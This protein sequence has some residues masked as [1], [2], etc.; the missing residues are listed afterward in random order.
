M[1]P[2]VKELSFLYQFSFF[3]KESITGLLYCLVL[4]VCEHKNPTKVIKTEKIS[5]TKLT[6]T[7]VTKE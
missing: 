6:V 4:W 1:I 5:Q 2:D 3:N 7:T